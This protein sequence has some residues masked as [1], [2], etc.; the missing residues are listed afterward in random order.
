[1]TLDDARQGGFSI[2]RSIIIA[3]PSRKVFALISN[4]RTWEQWHPSGI[5]DPTVER[6]YGGS[7]SGFGARSEWRGQRS[8]A[9]RMEI[10]GATE[11]SEVVVEVEFVKP[12]K[13]RNVNRFHLQ[14]LGAATTLTWSMHG[15]KPLRA[16]IMGLVFSM[17]RMM[18][19]HF[20]TG[21][22]NLKALAET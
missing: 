18:A 13:V 2:E 22:A 4:L 15:P 17:D 10:T 11:P 8:G 5:D 12:F 14:P 1:M 20:D 21:L 19:K 16:R 7:S 3:A 9:G 6:A